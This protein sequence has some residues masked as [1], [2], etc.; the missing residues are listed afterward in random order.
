M[1]LLFLAALCFV[2]L[3][4]VIIIVVVVDGG[5]TMYSIGHE[6]ENNWNRLLESVSGM[7]CLDHQIE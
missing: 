1:S 7:E 4:L 5:M 3:V 6:R 2:V